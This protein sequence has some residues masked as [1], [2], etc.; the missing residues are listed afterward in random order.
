MKNRRVSLQVAV[1]VVT[2]LAP[3]A[4][5]IAT[6]AATPPAAITDDAALVLPIPA[7][8]QA[9]GAPPSGWCGETAIQEALLHFGVWAP[10]RFINR[11][12]RPVHPDLYSSEIPVALTELGARFVTYRG[13]RG[14]DAYAAWVRAALD[15]GDPVLAGLKILPTQHPEWGLDHFVLVIGHGRRGLLVNTTWGK[16]EWVGDT[17]TP[18]LSFKNAFYGIRITGVTLPAGAR[19]ARVA[20]LEE[21]SASVKLRVTCAAAAKDVVVPAA[22]P[23]RHHCAP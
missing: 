2:G 3:A 16:R 17:S 1:V 6:A 19:A 10:Q 14:F 13:A 9:P 15:A 22:G 7:R 20:V 21:S 11:A 18:G 5:C 8:A 4:S 12:G 23:S